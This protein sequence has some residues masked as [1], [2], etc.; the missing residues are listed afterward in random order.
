MR[1]EYNDTYLLSK[2]LWSRSEDCQIYKQKQYNV[3]WAMREMHSYYK[4]GRK[5]WSYLE[6]SEKDL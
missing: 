5:G 1:G 2:S 6:T 4:A 3:I